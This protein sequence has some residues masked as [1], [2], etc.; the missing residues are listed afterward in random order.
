MG[1]I[2][3]VEISGTVVQGPSLVQVIPDS[4]LHVISHVV[5]AHFA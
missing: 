2:W 3:V 1:I 5:N 4:L